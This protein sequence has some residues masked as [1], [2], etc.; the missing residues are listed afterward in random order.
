MS[1]WLWILISGLLWPGIHYLYTTTPLGRNIPE[2]SFTQFLIDFG[3]FGLFAGAV[4]FLV[5]RDGQNE[6]QR[7]LAAFGYLAAVPFAFFGS[8][9]AWQFLPGAHW[10]ILA[11][12]LPLAIGGWLGSLVGGMGPA[13]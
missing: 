9:A 13:G 11:G 8:Y 4:F 3:A 10:M 6:R 5:R 2:F 7:R 1:K 12:C